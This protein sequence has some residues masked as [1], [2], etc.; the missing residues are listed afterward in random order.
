M[1]FCWALRQHQQR[2][3]VM[4]KDLWLC[5]ELLGLLPC[6][7][8]QR[9]SLHGHLCYCCSGG[10]LGARLLFFLPFPRNL[11]LR[12]AAVTLLAQ[13]RDWQLWGGD[14]AHPATGI[15]HSVHMASLGSVLLEVFGFPSRLSHWCPELAAA[16]VK[17]GV[18]ETLAVLKYFIQTNHSSW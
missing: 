12:G 13:E 1:E 15:C 6:W 10:S 8:V 16:A 3:E 5:G 4:K 14:T 2:S 18:W 17:V 7:N 11:S 9:W